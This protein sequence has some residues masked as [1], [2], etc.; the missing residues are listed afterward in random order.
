MQ[1]ILQRIALF[2]LIL[3]PAIAHPQDYPS[4]PV[5][6]IATFAQGGGADLTARILADRLTEVW[7]QQVV[8]E[9]RLG[10]GGTIG[11]EV[12]LRA[13]AD[14]YT[15]LLATN[16]HIIS[17]VVYPKVS[18]DFMKDFAPIGLVASSPILLAVHPGFKA[19]NLRELTDLLRASPGKYS[20]ASCN[21]ASPQHFAMETYKHTMGLFAVHIPHRGC[22]P[23]AIDAVAGH[24]EIVATSIPSG[25]PFVRQGK[26]KPI[27]V[28]SR[29]RTPSAPDIPTARE[30]GIKELADFELEVYYGFM[31]PPGTPAAILAK[32]EKDAH[33]VLK[34]A[35]VEKKFVAAGLDVMIAGPVEMMKKINADHQKY[36][37]AAK[38]ANI[39]P[40]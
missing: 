4:K 27:A 30:S 22:T 34:T 6:I 13:P 1:H 40:E 33:A 38:L 15:L 12:V 8:V 31:A 5:R 28:M 11:A 18:Y 32:I 17:H 29:E 39:K 14:G 2:L 37:V 26:L 35:D 16:T 9:N 23:A 19:N 36:A 3:M 24:L 25:L 10:G 21:V 7:K 20:Y